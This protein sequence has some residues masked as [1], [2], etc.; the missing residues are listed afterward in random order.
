[1]A[2]NK[3]AAIRFI[4]NRMAGLGEQGNDGKGKRVNAGVP[5]AETN[6]VHAGGI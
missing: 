3:R 4:A 6:R 2:E 5:E 1:M